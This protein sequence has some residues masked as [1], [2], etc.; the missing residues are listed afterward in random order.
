M[1]EATSEPAGGS[2]MEKD[3]GPGADQ[4]EGQHCSGESRRSGHERLKGQP[5]GQFLPIDFKRLRRAG[6]D[7]LRLGSHGVL[8]GAH[9]KERWQNTANRRFER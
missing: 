2:G 7:E 6:G 9:R 5:N 1:E 3:N 8:T 4:E